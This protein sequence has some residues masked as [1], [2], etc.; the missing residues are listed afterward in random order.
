MECTCPVNGNSNC[1][2]L[3]DIVSNAV[4]IR[5]FWRTYVVVLSGWNLRL[6][7]HAYIPF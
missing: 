1:F 6:A 5:K 2:Q 3:R 4:S 7:Q